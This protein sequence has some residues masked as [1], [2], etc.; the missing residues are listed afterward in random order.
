[1]PAGRRRSKAAP[2][3]CTE[4]APPLCLPLPPGTDAA[5]AAT[6]SSVGS[7]EPGTPVRGT[8]GQQGQRGRSSNG[9]N[10]EGAPAGGADCSEDVPLLVRETGGSHRG[11]AGSAAAAWP[12]R[13]LSHLNHLNCLQS[14]CCFFIPMVI[15]RDCL[16]ACRAHQR[17]AGRVRP[18]LLHRPGRTSYV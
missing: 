12:Q 4:P 6:L 7:V 13:Q 18:Q 8:N 10:E 11:G 14:V 1:M 15:R 5:A 17:A 3:P 2:C 16:A 9:I